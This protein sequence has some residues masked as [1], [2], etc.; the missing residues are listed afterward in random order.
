MD[1]YFIV[2]AMEWI[3]T[4]FCKIKNEEL[5]LNLMEAIINKPSE[6][7]LVELIAKVICDGKMKILDLCDAKTEEE[8]FQKYGDDGNMFMSNV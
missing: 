5:K 3:L 2:S 8:Y 4:L 1:N 6:S 7:F